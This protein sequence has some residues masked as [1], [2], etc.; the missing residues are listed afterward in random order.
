MIYLDQEQWNAV[1]ES[2]S[3]TKPRKNASTRKGGVNGRPRVSDHEC[4]EGVLYVLITGAKWKNVP[5]E[6]PSPATCWRRLRE[7]EAHRQF[8]CMWRRYLTVIDTRTATI[9]HASFSKAAYF[10]DVSHLTSRSTSL[11]QRSERPLRA[12]MARIFLRKFG[13]SIRTGEIPSDLSFDSLL[14][15]FSQNK[16]CESDSSMRIAESDGQPRDPF[17][18]MSGSEGRPEGVSEGHSRGT[19]RMTLG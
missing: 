18:N 6:Y 19:D 8:E 12:N 3:K 15:E 17:M 7:W 5:P 10:Q 1:S 11:F 4:F 13:K 2:C 14:D 16:R 9:W